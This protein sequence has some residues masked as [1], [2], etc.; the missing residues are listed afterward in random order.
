[1]SLLAVTVLG[2]DRPGI[3]AD[4]TAA[5]SRL[6]GNLEDS[7]M[8]LLRGA[9]AMLLLVRCP[10]PADEVRAALDGLTADGRL[11][12]EVRPVPDD[13]LDLHTPPA[14]GAPYVLSVHGAD[15]P[16]IVSALT[17]VVAAAGGNVTDLTTRLTGEPV[18]A[19]GRGDAAR[20]RRPGRAARAPRP[21]RRRPGRR[22]LAA[23]DRG[24]RA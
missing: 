8:T 11:A 7:T 16:G 19:P 2:H 18:R 22:G 14:P 1:M 20:R 6:G 12:V 17:G 13:G 3:V 4:T 9:F 5:L 10:A 24:R 23:A 21:D 15:R